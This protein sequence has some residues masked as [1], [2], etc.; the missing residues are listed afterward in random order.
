MLRM[1]GAQ[2]PG[3]LATVAGG[4]LRAASE[5]AAGAET[6]NKHSAHIFGGCLVTNRFRFTSPLAS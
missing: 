5:G 4:L 1:Q 6:N 2:L 3:T